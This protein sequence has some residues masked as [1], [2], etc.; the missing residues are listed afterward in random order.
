AFFFFLTVI[1]PGKKG[2]T[3]STKAV[4]GLRIILLGLFPVYF[5]F[6]VLEKFFFRKK[7][8]IYT[9]LFIPAVILYIYLFTLFSPF[10]FTDKFDY[11]SSAA[12]VI[13]IVLTATSLKAIKRSLSERFLLQEIK[14]K[15][16]Q[17]ELELL[18]TQINPHFLF[19]TL[20]NLYGMARKQE[21]ATADGIARLSHLMRYMIHDSQVDRISLDKE[22]EQ[23]ER[24]IELQKLRFT[25]EDN[26]DIDFK[27]EGRTKSAL[28]PPMLMIPFVENAFKH[29]ISLKAPS[30]IHIHLKTE[31]ATLHLSIRNSCHDIPGRKNEFGSGIGLQNVKRRLELLYPD[32]HE[33]MIRREGDVYEVRLILTNKKQE[34]V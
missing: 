30:F 13:F 27:I 5:H 7:Y 16:V 33:L 21:E 9:G 3:L 22:I 20:N 32:S 26:I 24:L 8:V 2:M 15:Q 29:G 6:F 10:V 31:P 4:A 12:F 1:T 17:T 34:S 14:A 11:P 23:I 19:N 18:K 25:K 28:I